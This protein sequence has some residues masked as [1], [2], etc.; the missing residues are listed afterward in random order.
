[1]FNGY[2]EKMIDFLWGIRFNNERG[3]FMEHKDEYLEYLYKPT[4]TLAEEVCAAL[5]ERAKDLVI[6]PHVT[7]IYRDA[8]RLH[9]RGPYKDGL[10]FSMR[11][12]RRD[13]REV[14]C[15]YF[16]VNPESYSF[17]MG[18]YAAPPLVMEAFRRDMD[19]DVQKMKKLLSA[20][21]T[22]DTFMLTGEEYKRKKPCA[23][24]TFAPWY[25]RRGIALDC[26][27]AYDELVFSPEL[28]PTLAEEFASLLPLYRYFEQLF[29]RVAMSVE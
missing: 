24:E 7:R 21:L 27:R 1:M 3:W 11:R 28:V 25:N 22:N 9:G 6:E 29:E 14:P 5:N 23:D 8:R 10:W 26:T 16:E 13:W 4:A 12:E 15:F 19:E 2:S 20:V 17:G 18:F